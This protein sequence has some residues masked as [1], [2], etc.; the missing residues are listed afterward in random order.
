ME[1]SFISALENIVGAENVL[2]GREDLPGFAGDAE[3]VVLPGSAAET[4]AVLALANGER[5]PVY[6]RGAG[7]SLSGGV[8]AKGGIVLALSRMNKLIEIDTANLVA[9]AE[10]GAAVGELAKAVAAQGLMY[11]PAAGAA[12]AA[13]LG[14]S[15]AGNVAGRQTSK[16]GEAKHYVMGLEAVLADGRVLA[17][18]GKTVKDVAGYDLTKLLTGSAGT[19]AV[20]TRLILKLMPAPESRKGLLAVFAAREDAMQALSGIT[21]ARIVPA[22]LEIIDK[23]GEGAM[24]LVELDGI[25]EVVE[26]ETGKVAAVL[27]TSMASEIRAL[28]NGSERES[29]WAAWRAAR[30]GV[31]APPAGNAAALAAMQAIK[32]ALD[33][34]FILSPGKPAGGC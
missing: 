21:A 1:T 7:T 2:T 6:P 27:R 22:A 24:L 33:P 23:A 26:Q 14:G 31:S 3:A 11:P 8:Q 30:P 29:L 18:G 4:S 28:E 25:A 15:V 17:T 34:N 9:V 13:S 20:I 10:A 5:V 19:L 12:P 16:Y 32:K